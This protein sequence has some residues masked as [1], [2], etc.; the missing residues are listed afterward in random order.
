MET[1]KLTAEVS[2]YPLREDYIP[3]IDAFI[4][5]LHTI[6]DLEVATTATSTMLSGDYDT[7]FRAVQEGLRSSTETFGMQVLVCKFF[8]GERAVSSW[9]G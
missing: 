4:A 7:V 3:A 1:T 2:L 9:P 5:Q 8:V 6:E